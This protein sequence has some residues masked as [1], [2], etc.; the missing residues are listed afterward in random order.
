MRT[1]GNPNNV[2]EP[3]KIWDWSGWLL[4]IL[5]AAAFFVFAALIFYLF[6]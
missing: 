1:K 5:I 3:K 4:V 6:S 2:S